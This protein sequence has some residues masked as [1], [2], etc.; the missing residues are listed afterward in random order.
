[1]KTSYSI[2]SLKMAQQL[3]DYVIGIRRDLHRHPE[4]GLHEVRTIKVVTEELSSMGIGYEIVPNGGIIGFIEGNQAGKTLI[5]RADLDAL[6]MKEE[7]TNLKMK[8]VVVS[9]TDQA[10]HTCG[11]DGHTAMLLG[12]AKILSQNKDKVK[13]KVLLAFEQGEEMGG[14]IFSLLKRLCEIGADGVWGIHLKS[15]MP[16]GKI[17]VEAGPRMAAS[18]SF[19][20]VIKGQSGHGSRPDLSIA[21]LDCFT[22]FYNNLKTMRL[23]TLDP[24]KTITYSIGT[25]HSGTAIN[26]IPESLQFSGTAR[27]LDFEQGAHAANEFKRILEKVCELHHCTFEFITEPKECDL[28]VSNQKDCAQLAMAAVQDAVGAD[29]LYATPA[30]MASESFAF[31]EKYFPGVFAFVGIQNLEKG[32]GAEHHNVYFDIDEDALK[33]GVAATVQYALYFLDNENPIVFTPDKRDIKSL[34]VENGFAQLVRQ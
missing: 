34:F 16:T 3:E 28:I 13:G 22:D 11:H 18:F 19:N 24:F 9:N 8:K 30:W 17:S 4:I 10:A 32:V 25:I 26:I 5:L 2:D 7:E 31:Y 23:S 33:F 27:Y 12:A 6:P 29:A 14:G 21:P 20:V 1:M 15:D